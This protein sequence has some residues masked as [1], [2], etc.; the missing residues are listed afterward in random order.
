MSGNAIL[1]YDD[2]EGTGQSYL[3]RLRKSTDV[4][5]NFKKMNCIDEKEF[6]KNM[7]ELKKRQI[8]FRNGKEWKDNPLELDETSIFIVDYDLIKTD[9]FTGELA[10]KY[11]R[12]FSKCRLVIALNQFGHNPFDLTLK[13]HP[14]SYADLNIGS[15]QLDNPGLWGGETKN[16]RPWYWPDIPQYLANVQRKIDDLEDNLDKTI[17]D[18]F[19]I[20]KEILG[21][22][23]RSIIEFLGPDPQKTTF[24]I[25]LTESG[26]G[27]DE[28]DKSIEKINDEILRLL[29]ASRISKWLEF[30]VLPGQNTLIDAPHLVHRYPSL[31]SGNHTSI[32]SWNKTALLDNPQNIGIAYEKIEK[33]RFKKDFW[34]S[35]PAWFWN[36]LSNYQKIKEVS[37][38][39]TR[40]SIEFVFCEDSSKFYKKEDGKEFLAELDSPYIRRYVHK[41]DN[42]TYEPRFRFSL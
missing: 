15:D 14:K 30:L 22:I 17:F 36:E 8:N 6:L 41:F 11:V 27:L 19:G 28:K 37:E 23:P 9:F 5:K 24:N 4:Q 38:P 7:K 26:N 1:I 34:L 33:F 35:R 42:V 18:F 25:F 20:S 10:S 39:W 40:E 31:L 3:E 12:C 13:C 16:F 29:L 21:T 2:D 32:D